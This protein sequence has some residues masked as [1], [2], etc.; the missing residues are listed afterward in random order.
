MRQWLDKNGVQAHIIPYANGN[1][2]NRDAIDGVIDANVAPPLMDSNKVK[3]RLRS[4]GKL[5]Y[6]SYYVAVNKQRPDLL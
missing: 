4:I 5:G 3:Q 1:Q 6:S 2:R